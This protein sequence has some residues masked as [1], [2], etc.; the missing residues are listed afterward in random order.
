MANRTKLEVIEAIL[1]RIESGESERSACEAEGMPRSTFRQTAL[2]EQMGDRYERALIGLATDQAHKIDELVDDMKSGKLD[3]QIGR[4]E[5]DARKWLASKFLPKQYGDKVDV[6]SDNKALPT[7]SAH[8]DETQL[9]RLAS[10]YEEKLKKALQGQ[11]QYEVDASSSTKL[12]D[13]D[14]STSSST[15]NI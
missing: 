1:A 9:T 6:T 2:R 14:L 5:L 11:V 13:S 4:I 8:L 12:P 3:Y 7:P 10:E 15:S